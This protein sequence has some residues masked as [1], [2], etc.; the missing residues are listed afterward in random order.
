MKH[1]HFEITNLKWYMKFF[2]AYI[3]YNNLHFF[4]HILIVLST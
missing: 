2:S 3:K 4:R 1:I